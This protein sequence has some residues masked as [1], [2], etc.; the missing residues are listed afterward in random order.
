M[1][2]LF[3]FVMVDG[4]EVWI[5]VE[6]LDTRPGSLAQPLWDSRP[7]TVKLER[8]QDSCGD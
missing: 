5:L 1:G 8:A 2:D 6:M 4:H 7:L 3:G